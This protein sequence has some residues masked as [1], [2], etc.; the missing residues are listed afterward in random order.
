[1]RPRILSRLLRRRRAPDDPWEEFEREFWAY[2]GVPPEHRGPLARLHRRHAQ[3][4][5]APDPV[6]DELPRLSRLLHEA[7]TL[8]EYADDLLPE[9]RDEDGPSGDLAHR[10]P[11]VVSRLHTM[12]DEMTAIRSPSL[13]PLAREAEK[14][15]NFYGQ[16]LYHALS[17]LATSWRDERLRE[18]RDQL[19]PVPWAHARLADIADRVDGMLGATT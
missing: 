3:P 14:V 19:R 18:Q 15:I 5:P 1:M 4:A 13:R 10:C 9:I 8:C 6:G 17:L 16:H 12:R 11:H 7:V 2:A